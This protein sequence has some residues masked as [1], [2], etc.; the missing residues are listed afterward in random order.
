MGW[1]GSV[2][3]QAVITSV[4]L[5]ALKRAGVVRVEPNAIENPGARSIFTTAVE[6]GE[7]VAEAGERMVKNIQGK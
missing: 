6:M 1:L 2:L 3:V 4:L 5:G 7:S